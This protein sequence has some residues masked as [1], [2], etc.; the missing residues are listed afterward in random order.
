MCCIQNNLVLKSIALVSGP[1]QSILWF[2]IKYK[3]IN[4]LLD[5]IVSTAVSLL[6]KQIF[7][8]DLFTR[9]I[10]LPNRSRSQWSGGARIVASFLIFSIAEVLIDTY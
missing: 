5:Y 8:L 2:S 3:R 10:L 7:T 6:F 9:S 4:F 1:N